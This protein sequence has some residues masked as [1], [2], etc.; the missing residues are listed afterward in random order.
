[1]Q[2]CVAVLQI[3]RRRGP[4]LGYSRSQL[5]ASKCSSCSSASLGPAST[6]LVQ[7]VHTVLTVL[8]NYVL[9]HEARLAARRCCRAA[10]RTGRAWP[11]HDVSCRRRGGLHPAQ[12]CGDRWLQIMCLSAHISVHTTVMGPAQFETH[13]ACGQ[14]YSI[15]CSGSQADGCCSLLADWCSMMY[16]CTILQV[17]LGSSCGFD[18]DCRSALY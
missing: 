3:A 2:C 6:A 10:G 17:P 7:R 4:R 18:G 14:L 12:Y 9:Q 15:L 1:M 16:H 5:N 11:H 8:S 13:G